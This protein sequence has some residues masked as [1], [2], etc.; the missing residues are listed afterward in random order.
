VE[1]KFTN[2]LACV[3]YSCLSGL[4]LSSGYFVWKPSNSLSITLSKSKQKKMKILI[5]AL[6]CSTVSSIVGVLNLTTLLFHWYMA[7]EVC[8]GNPNGSI[9]GIGLGFVIFSFVLALYCMDKL[10]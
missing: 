7:I 1:N 10:S 9:A 5:G 8:P 2:N 4:I 3:I 6:F